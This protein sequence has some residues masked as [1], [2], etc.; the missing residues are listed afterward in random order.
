[1]HDTYK[2][3]SGEMSSIAAVSIVRLVLAAIL[4]GLIGLERE[5]KH[6]TSWL[7]DELVYLFRGRA[8]YDTF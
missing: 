4:G 5:I 8:V 2:L 7:A 6:S 1:M 3:L